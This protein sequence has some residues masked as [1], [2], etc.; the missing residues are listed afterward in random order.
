M[1]FAE[2]Q[3]IIRIIYMFLFSKKF[4]PAFPKLSISYSGKLS[5]KIP[6]VGTNS[7]ITV[8]FELFE[9]FRD[10]NRIRFAGHASTPRDSVRGYGVY[11]SNRARRIPG[12]RDC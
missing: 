11:S 1:F 4:L 6:L 12:A 9:N 8:I 3:I 2:I 10:R 7:W 5:S